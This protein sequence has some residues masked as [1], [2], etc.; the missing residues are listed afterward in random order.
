MAKLYKG[1]V[2][3][4]EGAPEPDPGS[5]LEAAPSPRTRTEHTCCCLGVLVGVALIAGT[6]FVLDILKATLSY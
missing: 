3:R 4:K 1:L 2:Y 5:T 6:E